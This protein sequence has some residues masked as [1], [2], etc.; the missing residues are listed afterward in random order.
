ML[1]EG[2]SWVV[3]RLWIVDECLVG[4]FSMGRTG[5]GLALIIHC[6]TDR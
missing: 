3:D 2:Q 1:I 4:I 6:E 5:N